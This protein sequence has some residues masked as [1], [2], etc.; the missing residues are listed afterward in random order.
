MPVMPTIKKKPDLFSI[1]KYNGLQIG[2][3][4]I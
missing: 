1:N 3:R 4:T 2:H